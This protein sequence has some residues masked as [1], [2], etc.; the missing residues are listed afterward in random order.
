V[1]DLSS[2]DSLMREHA[3]IRPEGGRLLAGSENNN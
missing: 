2:K 1:A 3:D